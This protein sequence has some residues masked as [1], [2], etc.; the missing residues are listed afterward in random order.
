MS[1]PISFKV[2]GHS[3]LKTW[4]GVF[5]TGVYVSCVVAA[6]WVI[7]NTFTDTTSPT[8]FQETSET[9]Q[10]PKV[11]LL[12]SQILPSLFVYTRYGVIIKSTDIY[13]AISHQ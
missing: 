4:F 5:L 13:I 2:D 8:I 9:S 7:F 3:G 11:D 10:F 1:T 6:S 12:E